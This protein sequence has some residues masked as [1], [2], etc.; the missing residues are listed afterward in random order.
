[1]FKKLLL[2]L[3]V[4]LLFASISIA[5]PVKLVVVGDAGHNLKP[6]D[7]YA[8][9]IKEKFDV[10]LQVIGVPFG[11]LYEKEKVELIAGTGAY[12]ILI[13]YPRFLTEFAA[14]GWLYPFEELAQKYDPLLDDV[15]PGYRD[16]YCKYGGKL[17]ALPFDGDILN[18]YYRKDLIENEKEKANFKE[19]YGY[20]LKVP[21]TWDEYL[22][23]A[24][25][26]NRKAGESLGDQVLERDF[27]GTAYYGQ[28]DNLFAWW[29]N[30]FAGYGGVYFDEETLEP[31]INSE[32]ALKALEMNIKIHQ[33]CPPDVLAYGYEELKDIY[34]NGDCFMIVQWPCVGKKGADPAQSKI[35]GKVG[36]SHV[37]GVETDGEI[38]FRALMPCG[39]VLAIANDSRNQE[40]AFKVIHYLSTVTSMDDVSTAET[41]LDP[42]RYSHFEHPEEYDMFENVEDARIY[43]EGVQK[44]MEKGYPEM[45][46]PGTVEY[47][48]TLGV[49]LIKALS[50]EKDA[51]QA[52]DDAAQQWKEI[53]DRLGYEKQKEM[54]QA[55]VRGWKEAGLW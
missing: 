18:L 51:K 46:L 42:Y 52:L 47:E 55:L 27:Y 6:F 14:N 5:A 48:E 45:V 35:V 53:T 17:F 8:N 28:K 49:E 7:W 13:V 20:D 33:F 43:L 12:D 11:E 29:G 10:E 54:F 26:F 2:S 31:G 3:L 15:T 24:E 25:F 36:V 16:F 4:M 40:T 50:G 23:V 38:F 1:M 30:I 22:V 9:D 44:N 39:R 21:E 34:L 41:G 19:K 37:P 32:A